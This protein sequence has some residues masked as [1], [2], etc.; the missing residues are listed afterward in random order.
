MTAPLEVSDHEMAERTSVTP[1]VDIEW[2]RVMFSPG[3]CTW[4]PFRQQTTRQ[5][6]TQAE[7]YF[8]NFDVLRPGLFHVADELLRKWQMV[9]AGPYVHILFDI[10]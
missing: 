1:A 9:L 6:S 2:S 4:G 7:V 10:D 8:T 3:P 5:R